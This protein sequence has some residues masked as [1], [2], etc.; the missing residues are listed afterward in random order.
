M[1][2]YIRYMNAKN[3]KTAV[4]LLVCCAFIFTLLCFVAFSNTRFNG[5]A[6]VYPAEFYFEKIKEVWNKICENLFN[7]NL[8]FINFFR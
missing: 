5:F 7:N 1:E 2:S 4:K 8:R 3:R 6:D